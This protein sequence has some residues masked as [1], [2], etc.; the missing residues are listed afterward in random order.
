MTNH[1]RTFARRDDVEEV[2]VGSRIGLFRA[3]MEKAIVLNRVGTMLWQQLKT[4]QKSAS[5]VAHLRNHFP[6]IE[7]ERLER[8][9]SNYLE[10]L[11]ARGIIADT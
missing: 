7:P 9:V 6:E 5:L 11:L 2:P 3:G 1:E 10:E 8:D 4:P